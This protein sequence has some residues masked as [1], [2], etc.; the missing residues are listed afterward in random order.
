MSTVPSPCVALCVIDPDRGWCKGCQRTLVE[1]QAWP[2]VEDAQRRAILARITARQA[3]SKS[4]GAPDDPG[5][6]GRA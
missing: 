3:L 2:H 4:G 1:I 5:T 6:P